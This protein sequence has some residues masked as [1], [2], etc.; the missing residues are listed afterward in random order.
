MLKKDDVVALIIGT[1]FL[2]IFIAAIGRGALVSEDVAVAALETQGYSNIRIESS[3]WFAVGLRGCDSRDAAKFNAVA[4][5]PAGKEVH[6]FVCTGWLFKGAT[7]RS[8]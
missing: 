3:A 5:N 8:K 2:L 4:I 1:I 7:I 6:L